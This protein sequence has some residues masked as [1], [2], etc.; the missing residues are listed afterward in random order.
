MLKLYRYCPWPNVKVLMF[1]PPVLN[2]ILSLVIGVCRE[3]S[4]KSRRTFNLIGWLAFVSYAVNSHTIPWVCGV[5]GHKAEI[6][7][8]NSAIG[9]I[10]KL[11]FY[12]TLNI[13]IYFPE[14]HWKFNPEIRHFL[15]HMSAILSITDFLN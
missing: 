1:F 5:Q 15:F 2:I 3:R 6:V 14:V 13:W 10:A 4:F 12:N 8:E 11:Y 9:N 7:K